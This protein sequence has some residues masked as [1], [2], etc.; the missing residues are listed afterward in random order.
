M[1]GARL[2]WAASGIALSLLVAGLYLPDW[3]ADAPPA[4]ADSD[5]TRGEIARVV[6][7]GPLVPASERALRFAGLL[8]QRYRRQ[9]FAVRVLV[10]PTGRIELRCGA[11]MTR[12]QMATVATQWE[13]DAR[14][15][16]D[17]G[18]EMDVYETY[19]AGPRRKVGELRWEGVPPHPRLRFDERLSFGRMG[20]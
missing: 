14:A 13:A 9:G 8:T 15:L 2:L 5:P 18:F 6:G 7:V 17:R 11:N 10:L 4:H 12:R 20:G 19:A 3:S 1:G 16:F